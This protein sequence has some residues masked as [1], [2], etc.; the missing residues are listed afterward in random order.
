MFS[1]PSVILLP[2]ILLLLHLTS[3]VRVKPVHWGFIAVCACVAGLVFQLNTYTGTSA[4]IAGSPSI[5]IRLAAVPTLFIDTLTRLVGMR[6]LSPIYPWPGATSILAAKGLA[7]LAVGIGIVWLLRKHLVFAPVILITGLAFFPAV[8]LVVQY[9]EF[10]TAD[11]YCYFPMVGVSWIL[12]MIFSRLVIRGHKY[13]TVAVVLW[14]ACA[15][16]VGHLQVRHWESSR[17]IW[18]LAARRAPANSLV[19]NNLGSA[20]VEEGQLDEAVHAYERS[21]LLNPKN[22]RAWNNLGEVL[23]RQERHEEAINACSNAVRLQL[24][25]PQAH[26][27]WGMALLAMEEYSKA[28]EHFRFGAEHGYAASIRGMGLAFEGLKQPAKAEVC[29]RQFI[30]RQPSVDAHFL[31]GR[32]L[33]S[34]GKIAAAIDEL[35][36]GLSLGP[37]AEAAGLRMKLKKKNP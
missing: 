17:S 32:L 16:V 8:V 12:A 10:F 1:K 24:G 5:G 22:F 29:Y 33:A 11:R 26:H 20:L 6:G 23:L 28:A 25:Y 14:L 27:N 9:R 37:H 18:Q 31:L 7:A 36:K 15:A 30:K 3:L 35:D 13:G 19:F 4:A 2:G 21:L 34:Q